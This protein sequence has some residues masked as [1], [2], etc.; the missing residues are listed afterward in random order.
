MEAPVPKKSSLM[1]IIHEFAA[2]PANHQVLNPV[3]EL[4]A[5]GAVV[6]TDRFDCGS[7]HAS[8]TSVRSGVLTDTALPVQVAYGFRDS[9]VQFSRT[10]GRPCGE[11]LQRIP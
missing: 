3:I 8:G 1:K 4:G 11:Y 2:K 6:E 7:V 10:E 5:C 9:C